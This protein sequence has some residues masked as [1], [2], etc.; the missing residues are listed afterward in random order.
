MARRVHIDRGCSASNA[1]LTAQLD[2]GLD[3]AMWGEIFGV[4]VVVQCL[5]QEH[6]DKAFGRLGGL[7][8]ETSLLRGNDSRNCGALFSRQGDKICIAVQVAVFQIM[9]T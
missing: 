1:L 9:N 7:K 3:S 5:A 8:P 4:V 6:C 2:C